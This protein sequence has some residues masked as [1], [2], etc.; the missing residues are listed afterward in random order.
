MSFK[1]VI[2]VVCDRCG[3]V[4]YFKAVWEARQHTI[5]KTFHYGRKQVLTFCGKDCLRMHEKHGV[6]GPKP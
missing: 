5:F 1:K 3:I 6:D 4:Q 2:E